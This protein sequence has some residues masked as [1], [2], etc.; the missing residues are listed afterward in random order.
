MVSH[1]HKTI[2]VVW[3]F[4][5]TL[6]KKQEKS[7]DRNGSSLPLFSIPSAHGIPDDAEKFLESLY[8]SPSTRRAC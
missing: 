6:T 8:D 5:L 7:I 4:S 2:S 3:T 1:R